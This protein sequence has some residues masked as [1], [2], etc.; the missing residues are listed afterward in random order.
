MT[1]GLHIDPSDATP[2]WRQIEAAIQRMVAAGALAPGVAVPS[3]RELARAL[4][5]NPATAAKAYQRLV[6]ARVLAVR[7]GEGTF[8]ADAPPTM[9]KGERREIVRVAATRFAAVAVTAGATEPE[10]AAEL[11]SAWRTLA[12]ERRG[13]GA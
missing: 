5:I 8:V 9:S 11:S 3:V 10:A 1:A 7:R 13:G 4:R 2:I 12:R 6:E